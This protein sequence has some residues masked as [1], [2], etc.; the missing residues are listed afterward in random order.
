M[1]KYAQIFV[2]CSIALCMVSQSAGQ[3]VRA[4]EFHIVGPGG[5][6]AM[7]HPTV[8]PR[9][10]NEVLV[11]CDMTGAYI[12][13]DGGRSWRML[14]CA[15]RFG[16]S[17]SILCGRTLSTPRPEPCGAVPTM[18]NPGISSGRSRPRWTGLA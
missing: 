5:G 1:K 10:T 15:E 12:S 2:A 4:S 13:H 14:I 6:G 11:A 16:S 7:F 9:D 3:T 8:D 17:P 18:A